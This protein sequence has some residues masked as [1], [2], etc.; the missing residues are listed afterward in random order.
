MLCVTLAG[1]LTAAQQQ[2]A[3]TSLNLTAEQEGFYKF[4]LY[5]GMDKNAALIAALNPPVRQLFFDDKNCQS[6]GAKPGS[7]AYVA[8]RTQ[9]E[10]SHA[11]TAR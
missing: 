10:V 11:A 7:D 9:L 1:C 4:F 8:C 6:Y 3:Q 5:E 2:P